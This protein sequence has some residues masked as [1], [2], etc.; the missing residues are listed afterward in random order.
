LP[1]YGRNHSHRDRGCAVLPDSRK[2]IRFSPWPSFAIRSEWSAGSVPASTLITARSIS[3]DAPTIRA[4]TTVVRVESAASTDP[5][6]FATAALPGPAAHLHHVRVGHNVAAGINHKSGADRPL[7]CRSACWCF[8]AH[9]LQAGH[10]R[11]PES[12]PRWAKLLD[13]C[14]HGFVELSQRIGGM[15]LGLPVCGWQMDQ[16]K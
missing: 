12:A 13:Q 2:Q 14:I 11:S 4:G 1:R 10:N 7:P 9:L 8:H 5:S 16:Q 3:L 15:I 6:A